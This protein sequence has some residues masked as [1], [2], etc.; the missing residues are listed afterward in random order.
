VTRVKP[1]SPAELA[2]LQPGDVIVGVGLHKVKNPKQAVNE[3][4][5]A[6]QHD[7]NAL[8]LRI[9]RNGQPAFVAVNLNPNAEESG[10]G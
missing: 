7:R 9:I 6:L 4:S 3:I 8:A 1:G 5:Q 2:G 10:N